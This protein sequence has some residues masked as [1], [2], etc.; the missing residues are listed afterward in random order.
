MEE[1]LHLEDILEVIKKDLALIV[2]L[3]VL[4]AALAALVTLFL[5]TPRY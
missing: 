4:F 5:M 1:T 2:I 3:F